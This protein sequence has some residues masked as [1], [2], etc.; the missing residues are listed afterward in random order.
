MRATVSAKV[1]AER[2]ATTH[3]CA[4]GARAHTPRD[5]RLAAS[6]WTGDSPGIM[7][8]ATEGGLPAGTSAE[9]QACL[10][11][12]CCWWSTQ[13]RRAGQTPCL[14]SGPSVMRLVRRRPPPR[15]PRAARPRLGT[16]AAPRACPL[17]HAPRSG[18]VT[19]R[20]EASADMGAISSSKACAYMHVDISAASRPDGR[21]PFVLGSLG[22]EVDVQ[23]LRTRGVGLRRGHG[24]AHSLVCLSVCLSVCMYACMS[25]CR[26]PRAGS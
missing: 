4:R 11:P 9:T 2:V 18:S 24:G 19:S 12:R 23:R 26:P 20:R 6:G 25:V 13:W 17:A 7:K 5:P 14:R 16:G 10:R 1:V 21:A 8:G 3:T 22:R 15:I